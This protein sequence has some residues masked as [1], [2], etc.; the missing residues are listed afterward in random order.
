MRRGADTGTVWLDPTGVAAVAQVAFTSESASGWQQ[1][2]SAD[3]AVAAGEHDVRRLGQRQQR[4]CFHRLTALQIRSRT[5]CCTRSPMAPTGSTARPAAA[6]PNQSYQLEQLLHRRRGGPQPLGRRSGGP[7]QEPCPTEQRNIPQTSSVSASFS[8]ALGPATITDRASALTAPG[9]RTVPA[10]VSLDGSA[11]VATLTPTAQL[12]TGTTYT[13]LCR[14]GGGARRNLMGPR[15]LELHD[16]L[17]PCALFSA[18]PSPPPCGRYLRARR[19]DAGGPAEQLTSVRFYKAG[20]E[21]GN[22]TATIWTANG[23]PLAR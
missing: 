13:A 9:G 3:A 11:Q 12:A 21:T 2:D 6:F 7:A 8:R 14:L 18:L 4:L 20:G 16:R 22:H 19:E 17:C 5:A 1:Q 10:T 23:F 15:L